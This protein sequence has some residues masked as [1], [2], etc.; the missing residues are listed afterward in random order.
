M[1]Q[2]GIL[3]FC[4]GLGVLLSAPVEALAQ[5]VSTG[6]AVYSEKPM[7]A[8]ELESLFGLAA[9]RTPPPRSTPAPAR[10]RGLT[11]AVS[12]ELGSAD[13]GAE[14]SQPDARAQ[15]S[16]PAPAKS[17]SVPIQ[18]SSGSDA[19]DPRSRDQLRGLVD[20]LSRH[21]GLVLLVIGH[22]DD[23]GSPTVNQSLSERR[24]LAVRRALISQGVAEQQLAAMGQGSSRPLSGES[25]SSDRQRRVEFVPVPIN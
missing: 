24:A 9:P 16:A 14:G 17:I 7:S 13:S 23:R 25:P 18:F 3:L 1:T 21:G 19:V 20:L 4:L 2:R 8:D 15:L 5:N 12:V 10:T 6:K 11:R 22:T